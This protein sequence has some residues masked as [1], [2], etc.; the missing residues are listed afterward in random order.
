MFV[1][2]A[3]DNTATRRAVDETE[4]QKV[5]L[6]YVFDRVTLLADSSC[7]GFEADG[8]ASKLLNHRQEHAAIRV[9]ETDTVDL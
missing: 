4:L 8:T 9:I 3:R 1:G 7:Q 6:I 5:R 2:K